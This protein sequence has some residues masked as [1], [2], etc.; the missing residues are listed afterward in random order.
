MDSRKNILLVVPRMNIGG[1]ETYV[2]AVARNLKQS[3]YGVF[4]A[5]G[6]GILA[7]QLKEQG[8]P[9]FFL[10]IRASVAFSAYLLQRLVRKHQIDL[11]H[12]NSAAAGVT[13]VLV[14]RKFPSI[15]IIFTAHGTFGHNSKEMLLNECD[16]IVCV[17]EFVRQD[18]LR[19][20]FDCCRLIT[21]YSGIDLKRFRPEP[22]K[23]PMLRQKMGVREDEFVLAI[24]SR[25]KNLRNKGHQ[26]L[27]EIFKK[28]PA[29]QK[30]HLLVIGKGKGLW[31]LKYQIKK[32]H[33][34]DRMHC[35]GHALNVEELLNG[36]DLVV[37]PS[38]FE[39]FGLV[40]AEAMAM[41]KP[42]IAYAAGGTPEVVK[43]G[44]TGYLVARDDIAAL[45]DKIAYLA[46]RRELCDSMGKAARQWVEECFTEEKMMREI[47]DL[48]E[49]VLNRQA[50]GSSETLK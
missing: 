6:G 11:I 45:Y 36:V 1:A 32:H 3:G 42:V 4:V 12:A 38:Q 49:L 39:T 35:V 34:A 7:A 46:E 48:Y 37:L 16:R 13:A 28:Y 41:E 14:K 2:F 24:V 31:E 27:L 47:V 15:P 5:S 10:P 25:I 19:R 23:R 40:L 44:Q 33:L 20:G 8:I 17:S 22:Q 29:A 18:A 21:L 30:W 50:R 26:D 9:H 43:D